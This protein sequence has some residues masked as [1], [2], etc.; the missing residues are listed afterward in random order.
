VYVDSGRG[1]FL[2]YIKALKDAGVFVSGAGLEPPETAT[3]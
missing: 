2:P 3:P 1:S